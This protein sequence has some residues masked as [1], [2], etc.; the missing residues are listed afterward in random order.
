MGKKSKKLIVRLQL[1]LAVAVFQT[2]R[3]SVFVRRRPQ[4]NS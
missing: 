4:N 2:L 3:L 1:R